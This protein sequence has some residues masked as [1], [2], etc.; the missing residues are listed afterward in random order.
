MSISDHDKMILN[1]LKWSE[2]Q[3]FFNKN[4]VDDVIEFYNDDDDVQLLLG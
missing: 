2:N 1:Y 4:D 3:V